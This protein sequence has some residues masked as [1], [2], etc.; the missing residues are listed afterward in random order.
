MDGAFIERQNIETFGLNNMQ[1]EHDFRVDVTDPSGGF[2]PG[3]LQAGLDDSSIDLQGKL[4][5][6]FAQL[7]DDRRLLRN[8]IFPRTDPGAPRYLPVNLQRIV[9][10]AMQ[11]FH[12]DRRKPSDLE[13]AYIIDSVRDLCDRLV[14]VR[15]ESLL[16]K[17]AQQNA[18][19]L[20][21]MLLRATFATHHVLERYDLNHEA[22]DWVLG[23]VEA[24]FNLSGQAHPRDSVTL[25]TTSGLTVRPWRHATTQKPEHLQCSTYARS[26][27]RQY[28]PQT[29]GAHHF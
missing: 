29:N 9:Q 13:P 2:L 20:F 4:D 26:V 6:E 12:I 8:W 19:L 27:H 10:N 14:V 5:E 7:S 24:K 3:V 25:A 1:F 21:H 11:I 22:F 15:G 28:F 23:E 17:E 18:T 16:S